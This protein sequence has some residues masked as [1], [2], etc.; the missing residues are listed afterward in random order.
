M[1]KVFIFLIACYQKAISPAF[2]LLGAEC[3]FHPSCSEYSKRAFEA[4][5]FF[6]AIFLTVKRL[7]KCGPWNA[8]GI[9][10]IKEENNL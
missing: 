9:D 8:G 5:S 3:R 2:T 4:R 10:M 1:S 6:E 7:A